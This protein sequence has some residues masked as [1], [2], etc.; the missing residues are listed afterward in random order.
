M[1]ATFMYGAGDVRVGNAPDPVLR[2]P[3]DAIVRDTL[4]TI[5][6]FMA[7]TNGYTPQQAGALYITDGPIRD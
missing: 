1:R 3:T 5:G 4:A 6:Q 7:G 2:Q